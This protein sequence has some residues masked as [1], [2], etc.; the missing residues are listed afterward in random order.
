MPVLELL[1]LRDYPIFRTSIPVFGLID[2]FSATVCSDRAPFFLLHALSSRPSHLFRSSFIPAHRTIMRPR[3]CPPLRPLSTLELRTLSFH[4]PLRSFWPRSSA[5]VVHVSLSTSS[6]L[7]HHSKLL[8]TQSAPRKTTDI[9]RNHSDSQLQGTSSPS[10]SAHP[11]LTFSYPYSSS[12]LPFRLARNLFT[13]FCALSCPYLLIVGSAF[14]SF[15]S[16]LSSSQKASSH[17]T[18]PNL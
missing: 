4:H 10:L 7:L 18:K 6:R 2:I 11:W 12:F 8:S 13:Y 1:D 5:P 15:H 9:P 3:F 17:Q 14:A 16:I